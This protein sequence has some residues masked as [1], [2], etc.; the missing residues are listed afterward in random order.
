VKLLLLNQKVDLD[1]AGQG[2]AIDWMMAFARRVD[3]LFVITHAAGRL[4]D[5]PNGRIY[6]AGG[7]RGGWK[8]RRIFEF[9][10][11]LLDIVGRHKIDGCFVHMMPLFGVL[12]APVLKPLGVPMVQW[13]T[14]S[15]TPW[16]IRWSHRMVDHVVT[17]SPESFTLPS[18]K[19][20]VTGHGIP[21][22]RFTRRMEEQTPAGVPT[23]LAVGRVSPVKRYDLLV[24]AAAKLRERAVDFQLF[25]LG[26]LRAAGDDA[27][28]RAIASQITSSGLQA[29][30]HM[31]GA[32]SREE[33]AAW[34]RRADLLVHVCDSGLDKAVLEAMSCEVPVVTSGRSFKELLVDVGSSV[35]VPHGD[36]DAIAAAIETHLAMAPVARRELGRRLR[37]IV[38][39]GHDQERLVTQVLALIA[40]RRGD[41][42]P[43]V[44]VG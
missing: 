23:I 25:I 14:H 6:S 2:V 36:V 8:P 20:R 18:R 19:V 41:R 12:A 21:T 37:R 29:H 32:V 3:E 42:R 31:V 43:L 34:Y 44:M 10:R 1:D 15:F 4:P 40:A 9:Y 35:S 17:A 24:S 22:A 28:Q 11:A 26:G 16:P 13:Y 7:E 39:E 33:M 5:L 30:V 38:V 27:Y